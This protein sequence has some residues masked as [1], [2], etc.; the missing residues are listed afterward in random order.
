MANILDFST[1]QVFRSLED[2]KNWVQNIARSQGYVTVTKRSKAAT[3]GFKSKVFLCCDRSIPRNKKSG[4]KKI[5]CPFELIAKYLK[6]QDGW[7]LQVVRDD[8][9]H[10][11]SMYME[12]T[13]LVH[14][15][16]ELNVKPLD[17]LS[18]I[19]QQNENNVS[20]LKTIY[21]CRHKFMISQ[22]EGRSPI[23]NVMHILHTKGY[24]Y[25]YRLNE[26]TNELEELFFVHPISLQMWQAF[27]YVVLMDATYKTNKYNLPFLEIVGVT[28]TRLTFSIAFAFMHSEKTSNYAW[29]L[30]CL[31]LTINDSFCPCVIVT[32]RDLAL[33]KACE[34]VFPQSNHLLCRWHIFNDIT[35][36]CRKHIKSDKT[37]GSLHPIWKKLVESP[38]PSAYMQ[39]YADLQ[40]LLSKDPVVFGYLYNTWL[41]KYPDKF[42]SLWTDKSTNFGN[43]TTN[44][45]ESQH[46]K[47]KK[48]LASRKCDLDKFKYVIETVVQSYDTA[49]KE[50]FTRSIIIRKPKFKDE[51][52]NS[53]RHHVSEHALDKILEELCRLKGFVPT[54]ENCGCQLRTCFGLPCAHEL[55]MYVDAGSPI[56]LDSIDIFWRMLDFKPC[57]FVDYGNLN[58]VDHM[59]RWKEKFNNQPDHVKYSYIR[60]MEEIID[61]SKIMINEPSVKKNNRGRPKVKRG[62][63]Q[64]QAPHRYSCSEL[65]QEPPRHSSSFFDLNDEPTRHSSS[66]FDLNDEPTRHNSSFFDLNDEPTRH[67]S[68]FFD[69]NDEPTRHNSSFFDLNDEPTRHNSSFFDLNDEPARHSSF[70]MGMNEE[71]IDQ[72]SYQ[73]DLN[74]EQT[75][76]WSY[77][78]DLKEKAAKEHSSLL[79]EIPSIFHPYITCIQNVRGDGNCGFR[80]VAV[81]LGYDE[82]EWLFIRQQLY[83]ELLT[84]YEDYSRVFI[85]CNGVLD[86][87]SFFMTD[88]TAPPEHY[89]LMPQTGILIANRF[90]VI[91]QFLTTVGP[92]T[93][94]PLWRGPSEFQNHRVL[95][96]HLYT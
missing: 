57:V 29:A 84:S 89:M 2:L 14:D 54:L 39:A 91:V 3:F 81:C 25:E 58:V 62:H 45:V 74:E 17:I 66:F 30:T 40:S 31:K 12:E 53:L 55:A 78:F 68:S 1:D 73:F 32:D 20:S 9:N 24:S 60:M 76:Q 50:S 19:K 94:F 8:H 26:S 61:P 67:N 36:H 34:D 21:N 75:C 6:A 52:F 4:N 69:L 7:K 27:P 92:V 71:P 70:F 15:L 83:D 87:L 37:W 11:P 51:I 38:T 65:N 90:G 80:S 23:Q 35:K 48:H 49:I 72:C 18:T 42:V 95:T 46:P 88:R 44:R 64:S 85:G 28:S 59:Q 93:F 5:N 33:M 77:Q 79:K 22:R 47:L 13:R 56:P 63:H 82:N 41:E 43:S 96:L 16:T 10:E 86:S